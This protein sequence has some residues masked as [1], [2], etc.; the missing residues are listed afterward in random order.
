MAGP[1]V[2]LKA[3]SAR[4]PPSTHVWPEKA[5]RPKA[6]GPTLPVLQN[7]LYVSH[8]PSK[9]EMGSKVPCVATKCVGRKNICRSILNL[10][11]N[12]KFKGTVAQF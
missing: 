1:K 5:L 4:R 3:I 9:Q 10:N 2:L 11:F 8:F 6:W 12:H 7:C